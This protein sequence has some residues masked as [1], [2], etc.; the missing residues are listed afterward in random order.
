MQKK[1]DELR[2]LVLGKISSARDED[3]LKMIEIEFLGRKGAL[4][5]LLREVPNLPLEER[6]QAGKSANELKKE[7]EVAVAERYFQIEE[8]S[9]NT[10]IASEWIDITAPSKRVLIGKRHPIHSFIEQAEEVF[11]RLGF[12]VAEGNEI[13]DEWHNFT[14]LNLPPD[15][16]ARDMQATFWLQGDL[17]GHVL[18]TQTSDVQIRFMENN[19]PPIRIIAPG[20]VYRKDSDATHS[21]MFHQIEGLMIDKNISLAHL[22]FVLLAALKELTSPD[23][24][25]RFRLSYFP[26]T[27][28]S[29][30]MD[31]LFKRNGHER[32]LEIGGAGMVH[33]NVLK[34]CGLDPSE[35]NGFAFGLGIERQIMIKHGIGDLRLFFENDLRFLEQF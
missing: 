33:P 26:F 21:P 30:E 4:T 17:E 5:L 32:W 14:A 15:H 23:I 6:A 1:L 18:R 35:W 2:I 20:K 8:S 12:R 22:R 3:E 31:A 27:E 16:P 28:P 10:A 24:D 13:E 25:I 7:I 9:M 34:N 19:T 29:F 11:G